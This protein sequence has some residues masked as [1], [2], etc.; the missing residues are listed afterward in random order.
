MESTMVVLGDRLDP[1]V[2][3]TANLINEPMDSSYFYGRLGKSK[4]KNKLLLSH[5]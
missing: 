4:K 2:V 3:E 1:L 5:Y